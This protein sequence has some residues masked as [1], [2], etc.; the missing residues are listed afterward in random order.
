M[1]VERCLN[2]GEIKK[3]HRKE[4]TFSTPIAIEETKKKKP[5]KADKTSDNVDPEF[6]EFL[7]VHSKRQKDKSIWDNDGIDGSTIKPK[8]ATEADEEEQTNTVA[9]NKELSDLQVSSEY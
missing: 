2:L 3:K 5:S 9:H 7:Q 4:D 1:Q 8:N 6:A